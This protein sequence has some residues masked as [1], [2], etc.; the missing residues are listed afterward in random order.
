M[1]IL[2]RVLIL[3]SIYFV[4]EVVG[5]LM[6]GSLALLADAGHMFADVAAIALALFASWFA[7]YPASSQKTFGYYRIEILAALANGLFLA[8]VSFWIIY[9]ATQ[10][11]HDPPEVQGGWMFI[12]ALGG[13]IINIISASL[14]HAEHKSDLNLKGAYLHVLGDLLGSVGALAAA[15][16]I[17]LFDFRLADPLFSVVIAILV[18]FSATKLVLEA[19]NILLEGSP[20]HINVASVKQE[21]LGL[22][23]VLAVHDLHVWTITS[24]KDAL[25]AHVVVEKDAFN[26]ETL[27]CIQKC[28][29]EKFGLS[30]VTLQLEP[31]DFEEDQEHC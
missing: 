28:L 14:L 25:A 24:G 30:H 5:G 13:L 7:Q 17:L 11:W 18:L 31:P 19:V 15:G 12:V 8:G 3:T 20:S 1:K 10:R 21:I 6:T 23:G 27:T 22:C 4:A 29:R 2:R 26:A 9:E 16:M